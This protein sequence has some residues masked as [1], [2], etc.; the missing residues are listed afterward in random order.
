MG[1]AHS[2]ALTEGKRPCSTS[3]LQPIVTRFPS[4]SLTVTI[5]A[6]L[7]ATCP[8]SQETGTSTTPP[9]AAFE[10]G[11]LTQNESGAVNRKSEPGSAAGAMAETIDLLLVSVNWVSLTENIPEQ[12]HPLQFNTENT[13]LSAQVLLSEYSSDVLWSELV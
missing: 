13:N 12:P 7:S 3:L 1:G 9:A 11:C 4:A 8:T 6:E 2:S 5:S 10:H